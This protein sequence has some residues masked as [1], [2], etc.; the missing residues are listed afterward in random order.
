MVASCDLGNVF[1][2]PEDW[3]AS[4]AKFASEHRRDGFVAADASG[5]IVNCLGRGRCEWKGIPLWEARVYFGEGGEG[6]QRLE[7]SLYN[8]G[9]AAGTDART[10][11][12]AAL[13]AMIGDVSKKIDPKGS[14]ERDEKRQN[15]TGG[16]RQVFRRWPRLD[17][18]A[19]LA[20]GYAEDGTADYVRLVLV[21]NG[22]ARGA[23]ARR[24]Q[25]GAE[26]L[27]AIRKN[28]SRASNG[29]VSVANV[30][31]VDQGQKGYC[32]VAVA[33]RVLRYFGRDVDEH[34]LAQLAG[35]TAG[36][37][38]DV[39]SM[40]EALRNFCGRFR[41]A[42]TD[43]MS[44]VG[45]V[46]DAEREI[47]RYNRVAKPMGRPTLKFGDFMYGNTFMMPRMMAAMEPEVVLEMRKKDPRRAKFMKSVKDLTDKGIPVFWGVTLGMFPEP[48]IP[49]AEGGH[50]RLIIGY[51][52]KTHEILYTDTWGA[53][54][55]L[56]RMDEDRAFAITHDLFY[57]R[58]L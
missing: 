48:D 33:E 40:R 12:K 42:F 34:Q 37:G 7:M 53:G 6:V 17:P 41:L 49:Q 8:R 47:D 10:M 39:A 3:K 38:T 32:A 11:T 29:D 4:S 50:M 18:A 28:V 36:G 52:E 45:G 20:W 30:P 5:K 57:L 54:H 51:N 58:P 27:S 25:T 44:M 56:K 31:M 46:R 13:E 1:S 24:P 2:S 23:A 9:D 55:E 19:E 15:R 22:G 14:P 43:I 16:G 26:I 35:S 21:P